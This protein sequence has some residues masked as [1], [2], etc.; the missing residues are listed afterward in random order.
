MKIN[1]SKNKYALVD[2][3]DYEF[4]NQWKWSLYESRYSYGYANRIMIVDGKR[5]FIS[6]SR[7]ILNAPDHMFVDHIN[8]DTLDNRRSNLR[9]ATRSQNLA[10]SRIR[11]SRAGFKGIDWYPRYQK[12]RVRVQSQHVGYFLNIEDAREAYINKAK[13]VFGEYHYA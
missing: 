4:L 10:N 2:D 12:W 5:K 11:K 13:E 9:L 1:L 7:L 8:H 3:E 6:M